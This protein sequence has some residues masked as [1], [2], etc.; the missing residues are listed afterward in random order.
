MNRAGGKIT[1][2]LER[3]IQEMSEKIKD[4]IKIYTD[5]ACVPNPGLMGC[6]AVVIWHERTMFL[7]KF[8]GTGTNNMAELLAVKMALDNL[9][10]KDIPLVVYSDSQYVV[11]V[12]PGKWKASR[13][14]LLVAQ[15]KN[16]MILFK[17]INFEW[18]KGHNGD[19][20][21]SIAD[22]LANNAIETKRECK[23]YGDCK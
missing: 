10:R 8:A 16:A 6:G 20:Y 2:F 3:I 9:K 19:R 18:V 5:G 4:V 22:G 1:L 21:N 11:N 13:N 12:L 17:H 15:I 7:S 23:Q 14:I